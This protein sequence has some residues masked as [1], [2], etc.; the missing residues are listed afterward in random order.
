M[1]TLTHALV[2]AAVFG[3]PQ[4]TAGLISVTLIG[5]VVPD[6][7]IVIMV[8]W[9]VGVNGLSQ[10]ELWGQAYYRDPWV[11]YSAFTN[12]FFVF[13]GLALLGLWRRWPWM[14]AFA[15]TAVLHFVGDIFLHYDDGHAHF[16]PVSLC[17]FYSPVS[18]WDPARG[19]IWWTGIEMVLA[20]VLAIMAWRQAPGWVARAY[21][22]SLLVLF[23]ILS[24]SFFV[25]LFDGR[26]GRSESFA[27]DKFVQPACPGS[28]NAAR[29][30]AQ[31][32]GTA[33]PLGANSG[34][35][36]ETRQL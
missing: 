10:Q 27:P 8:I 23:W 7:S 29:Q 6:L 11:T 9:E 1:N 31:T 4:L 25:A 15:G 34:Q 22:G 30:P 13:G 32:Q 33:P 35:A 3:R 24:L 36:R 14:L 26:D 19:G 17:V 16:W 12:S 28:A 2:G 18:Y 21:V 20:L 5:A